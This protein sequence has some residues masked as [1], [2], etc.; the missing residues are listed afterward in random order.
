MIPKNTKK[1]ILYLLR[2][3]EIVRK[4]E[5][6]YLKLSMVYGLLSFSTKSKLAALS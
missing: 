6:A 3:L 2:N 5:L 1:I 4:C